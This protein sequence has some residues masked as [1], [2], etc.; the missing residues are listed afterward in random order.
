MKAAPHAGVVLPCVMLF[1]GCFAAQFALDPEE[2]VELKK[3]PDQTVAFFLANDEVLDA[4]PGQYVAAT[5]S[6]EGIL[7]QGTRKANLTG[8]VSDFRGFLPKAQI[9]TMSLNGG[10]WQCLVRDGTVVN[11][12][13]V[14]AIVVKPSS[15]SGFWIAGAS[16]RGG[17]HKV[18]FHGFLPDSAIAEVK[19]NR[20]SA[21]G[22][23][24]T[25]A[26]F[27]AALVVGVSS[28]IGP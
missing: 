2:I 14:E 20:V 8:E 25:V 26:V 19:V 22:I 12:L 7:G 21:A 10:Q 3:E 16:Q 23:A 24:V 27:T 13:E 5:D 17:P 18:R 1:G 6:T 11:M 15:Q 9:D 4:Y 28:G